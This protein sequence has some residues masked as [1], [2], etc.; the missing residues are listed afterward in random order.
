MN[1]D[2][3]NN[4]E[5]ESI[6]T[7]IDMTLRENSDTAWKYSNNHRKKRIK[8]N[9]GIR[10]SFCHCAGLLCRVYQLYP[11]RTCVR[12]SLGDLGYAYYTEVI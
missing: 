7:Q 6:L 8:Q 9:D 11:T 5:A 2:N 3:K 10:A 4:K 1:K 12:P